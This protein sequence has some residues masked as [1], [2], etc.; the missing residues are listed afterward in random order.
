MLWN[1]DTLSLFHC[2]QSGGIGITKHHWHR[3]MYCH[4][5]AARCHT[6][7]IA[8]RQLSSRQWKK[9]GRDISRMMGKQTEDLHSF[10]VGHDGGGIAMRQLLGEAAQS[11]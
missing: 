3:W 7:I 1:H 4:V 5:V 2:G 10:G 9:C 6:S 8:H 11:S